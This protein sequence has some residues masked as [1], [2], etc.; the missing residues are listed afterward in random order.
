MERA[1]SLLSLSWGHLEGSESGSVT[2]SEVSEGL[3]VASLQ[4]FRPLHCV[5]QRV[6]QRGA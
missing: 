4:D 5:V 6:E 2:P 1:P 3:E